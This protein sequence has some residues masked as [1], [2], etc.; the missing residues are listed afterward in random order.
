MKCQ[1]RQN[2]RLQKLRTLVL[3]LHG[4]SRAH[5]EFTLGSMAA[6]VVEVTRLMEQKDSHWKSETVD[7][8]IHCQ[9]LLKASGASAGEINGLINKRISRFEVKITEALL[10]KA[11]LE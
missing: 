10:G 11:G 1:N 3:R 8:L 6:H 7:I 4:S 5:A 2:V 9:L